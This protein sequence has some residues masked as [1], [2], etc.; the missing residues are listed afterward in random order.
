[1]TRVIIRAV[2]ERQPYLDYLLDE[3]PDAEVCYDTTRNAMNTFL[4]AVDLAGKDGVLYLEDDVI[5]ADQF[6][7]RVESAISE[8][9]QNVIQFFSMRKAD[10]EIGSRWDNNF[11]MAQCFYFPPGLSAELAKYAK[12]WAGYSE[13]PT[14]LDTMICD[15][16]R[17]LKLKYWIHIPN[18]VDHRV[19]KSIID[20]RR[21]SKRV[22]KTFG[23]EQ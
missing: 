20:P 19:G 10:L 22:S 15:F 16:L 13:H 9:P 17:A 4:D 7:N 21:S 14:G 3:L 18:L 11:L 23:A 1:M 12:T 6:R 5:L 8:M 2:K